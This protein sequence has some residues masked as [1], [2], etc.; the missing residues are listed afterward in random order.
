MLYSSSE[1]YTFLG[2]PFLCM[3]SL[4]GPL[5][6]KLSLSTHGYPNKIPEAPGG[7][8]RGIKRNRERDG[9]EREDE[10]GKHIM[11]K[12]EVIGKEPHPEGVR[13][14]DRALSVKVRGS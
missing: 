9:A 5:P 4:H 14:A 1:F 11:L 6:G 7:R 8:W 10:K 3:S 12:A 2:S 13:G